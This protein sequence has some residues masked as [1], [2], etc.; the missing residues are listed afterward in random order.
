MIILVLTCRAEGDKNRKKKVIHFTP[1]DSVTAGDL[2]AWRWLFQTKHL[3]VIVILCAHTVQYV[4]NS[5]LQIKLKVLL[6]RR[7]Q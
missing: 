1:R 4:D 7:D 2:A 3:D 5:S 6:E